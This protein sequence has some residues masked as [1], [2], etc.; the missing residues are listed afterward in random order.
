VRLRC[1]RGGCFRTQQRKEVDNS[2]YFQFFFLIFCFVGCIT[3]EILKLVLRGLH[4]KISVQR[5]ILVPTQH[6][7]WD[8]GKQLKNL[9]EL[10]GRRT[11]LMHA[12]SNP[13]GGHGCL[14]LVSVM[15][16]R[17]DVSAAGRSLIRRSPTE[18]GLCLL[19]RKLNEEE[20]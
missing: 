20:A 5:G 4:E 6:L 18:C 11:F 10:A 1:W 19:P 17:V 2:G 12:G 3:T 13:A 14:S 9:I 7:L 15:C 16:S 8:R